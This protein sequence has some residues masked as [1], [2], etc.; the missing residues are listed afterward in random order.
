MAFLYGDME[1]VKVLVQAGAKALVI[2]ESNV[3]AL[4]C[5]VTVSTADVDIQRGVV[6]LLPPSKSRAKVRVTFLF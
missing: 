2:C 4:H 3:T 6:T 5:V 1:V